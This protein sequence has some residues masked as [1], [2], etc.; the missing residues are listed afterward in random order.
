MEIPAGPPPPPVAGPARPFARTAFACGPTR[1]DPGGADEHGAA[2]RGPSSRMW[3]SA[4]KGVH[5][6][7]EGVAR[8]G[9]HGDIKAAESCW[10]ARPPSIDRR[11]DHPAHEPYAGIPPQPLPETGRRGRRHAR[12]L[13]MVVDS[14]PGMMRPSIRA[15]SCGRRIASTSGCAAHRRALDMARTARTPIVVMR[16]RLAVTSTLASALGIRPD[17]AGSLLTSLRRSYREKLAGRR[18]PTFASQRASFAV[19]SLCRKVRRPQMTDLTTSTTDAHL[20]ASDRPGP[21]RLRREG[22]RPLRSYPRQCGDRPLVRLGPGRTPARHSPRHRVR[23]RCARHGR[24]RHRHRRHLAP[25]AQRRL[26]SSSS[27]RAEAGGPGAARAHRCR[28]GAAGSWR[29]PGG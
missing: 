23:P 17:T 12:A 13:S 15:T 14:P 2:A 22:Q 9:A 29:R 16:A 1:L 24:R 4:S 5:A 25:G 20:R 27:P 11:A 19:Q 21:A 8:G 6:A 18:S 7:A 26:A 3:R 10:S 28:P